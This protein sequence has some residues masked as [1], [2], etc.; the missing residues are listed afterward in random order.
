MKRRIFLFPGQGSQYVGMG[1]D[2][3]QK[4]AIAREIFEEANEIL[5]FSLSQLCFEGPE[6]QLRQTANTQPALLTVSYIAF[7]LLNLKPDLAAGHSLGEYT[8]LVAAGSL[9]FGEGLWLV[10]KRGEYMQEAVAPGKGSMAAVIGLGYDQV[11][12]AL[13]KVKS[14]LVQ[15]ANW[16]SEEQIVIAGETN[17]V[18]EAL[19]ILNPPRS[20]IL[21]VSG[22]FH[23]DLMTPAAARLKADL[24]RVVFKDPEFPV[25]SNVSAAPIKTAE[26]AKESLSRQITSPV[27]WYPSMQGLAD[28]GLDEA[29]ELGPGKVLSNLLKRISRR[30]KKIPEIYNI[31]DISTLEKFRSE[32]GGSF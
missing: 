11:E 22:P 29:V 20:V 3:Y 30:W 24:D 9:S 16:N 12:E 10:R 25:I 32:S 1:W 2:F 4:S 14:G 13:K 28:Y 21:P 31:E 5:K 15:I 19:I 8:A 23:T 6:E 7:R 27:K 17:A 18:Q 26:E